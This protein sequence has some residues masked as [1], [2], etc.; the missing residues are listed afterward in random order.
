MKLQTLVLAAALT[1]TASLSCAQS[2][3]VGYDVSACS[4]TKFSAVHAE[5]SDEAF[6]ITMVAAGPGEVVVLPEPIVFKFDH[7]DKDGSRYYTHGPQKLVIDEA[8][9]VGLVGK[10]L[11]SDGNI[12]AIVFGA[13]DQ[14]GKD[15]SIHADE[16]FKGCVQLFKED[17]SKDNKS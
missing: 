7:K 6:T 5:L 1:L 3:P 10:L 12:A 11:D 14:D 2:K 17:D 13:F 9:K 16:D 8:N 4:P 15:L